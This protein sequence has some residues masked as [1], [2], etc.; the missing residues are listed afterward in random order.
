MNQP[1]RSFGFFGSPKRISAAGQFA[2]S[3]SRATVAKEDIPEHSHDD[4]HI[5]LAV[6]PGYMSRAFDVDHHGAGFDLIY[7]PPGTVHQDC[8]FDT[9]GRFL[10]IAFPPEFAP[11]TGAPTVI[12]SKPG[13]AEA[14]RLLGEI[15]GRGAGEQLDCE[16]AALRLLAQV[17]SAAGDDR[18]SWLRRADD[19][20]DARSSD[21]GVTIA[22]LAGELDLHPVYF[23]RAYGAGK[24]VSPS[25]ALQLRRATAAASKLGKDM[26]MAEL[27]VECGYS[28]QSH[29]CRSIQ[30]FFGDTP[31]RL[32][33]GF[34]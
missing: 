10:S 8:F 33:R 3:L 2:F 11:A 22:S 1:G 30:R 14:A 16:Q 4:G 6:D 7:N 34:A 29:L 26:S 18:P 17:S 21:V 32:V 9:G 24:G 15:A 27:A 5:I 25:Q 31:S 20:I 28:D 12:R 23:A 13:L 19:L